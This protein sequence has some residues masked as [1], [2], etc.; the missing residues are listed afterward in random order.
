MLCA[1]WTALSLVLF[2]VAK[3][4]FAGDIK[5][6]VIFQQLS[7]APLGIVLAICRLDS[8]FIDHPWLNSYL[9][10]LLGSLLTI[11]VVCWALVIVASYEAARMPE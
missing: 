2:G 5:G 8:L 6:T 3:F 11:Y 7:V 4:H 1:A 10:G 9:V